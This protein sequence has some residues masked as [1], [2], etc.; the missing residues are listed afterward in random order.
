MATIILY[1]S[2]FIMR[3]FDLVLWKV[4]LF[5]KQIKNLRKTN[6]S[7]WISVEISYSTSLDLHKFTVKIWTNKQIVHQIL[8]QGVV[9][10]FIILHKN[11]SKSK[12]QKAK[13][14]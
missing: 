8:L 9:H 2:T 14:P 11:D 12:K 4:E 7:I 3:I 10:T 13:V 5:S 1:Q 6:R